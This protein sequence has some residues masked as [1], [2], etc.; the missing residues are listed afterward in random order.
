MFLGQERRTRGPPADS[1]AAAE[2]QTFAV[3]LRSSYDFC[4]ASS[5]DRRADRRGSE[6]TA[7]LLRRH[8][9]GCLPR[10]PEEG[11]R[12]LGSLRDDPCSLRFYSWSR[13]LPSTSSNGPHSPLFTSCPRSSSVDPD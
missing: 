3:S 10:D 12:A 2:A 8:P 4:P 11:F 13:S 7:L 1:K 9:R 5:R 6:D